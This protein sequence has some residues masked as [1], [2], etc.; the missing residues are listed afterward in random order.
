MYLIKLP[1]LLTLWVRL[2]LHIQNIF[3]YLRS[4]LDFT[5]VFF[6]FYTDLGKVLLLPEFGGLPQWAVV[7][8]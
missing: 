5:T 4:I 8:M 3:H 2:H 7:G 1:I 6:F